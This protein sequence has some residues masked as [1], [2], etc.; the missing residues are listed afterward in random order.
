MDKLIIKGGKELFGSVEIGGAK[1]AAVAVLPAAIMASKSI[2][3]ID[4]IPEIEDIQCEER[5]IESLG[6]K[7]TRVKN[8]VTIDSTMLKSVKADTDDVRKMRASYYLIGALLGRFKKASVELPGGCPIGVRP[9]DQHIKGFEA[10]GAR[11][12][13]EHGTIIVEADRLIGTNIYFDVVSVGATINV[14]L[15]ATLAEGTTV[16]EN[17]AKEPHVVDVANFLN[18]MGANIKGA[19]TDVI[20]IVGVKE[21]IGCNYSVIPDQI[22]AG[23]YMVAAAACGGSVTINNVIPKHLESISAKLVEMGAEVIE[24]DDS[25]TVKSKKNLKGVNIKTLPYPGF[26]TDVQQPMSTLLC[27]SQGRSIINESIFECRFKHIDELKKMGAHIKVEGR[28]AII[29]GVKKLT[30][31]VVKASDLRAGAAMVIAGLIAEGS[32]EVTSIEHIDRGYPH[33]ENKFKALG[34][35]IVRASQD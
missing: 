31:A 5:I 20:R 8:S 16:L 22:E 32:T 10:L 23:T 17:A 7:I 35:D 4:N 33:I 29:D 28:I 19:G 12:N 13:I 2:C 9:I 25:V 30:G 1:N 6:C 14:M 3:V 21:L 26:P 18:T 27:V 15:A 34:A 11:V 24:L